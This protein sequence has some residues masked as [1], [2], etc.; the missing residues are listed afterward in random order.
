M[1][2]RNLA[3]HVG[4]FHVLRIVSIGLLV[5]GSVLATDAQ[6]FKAPQAFPTGAN[7]VTDLR[8]WAIDLGPSRAYQSSPVHSSRYCWMGLEAGGRGLVG[9]SHPAGCHRL[10]ARPDYLGRLEPAASP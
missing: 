2:S 9:Q 8:R 5:A 7:P 6:I 3:S 4:I 10:R 1:P